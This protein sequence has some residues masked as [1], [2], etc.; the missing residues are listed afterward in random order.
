[1]SHALRFVSSVS[2]LIKIGVATSEFPNF[3]ILYGPNTSSPWG[4]LIYT[5][6]LQAQYNA[7]V[8]RELR[9]RNAHGNVFAMMAHPD[10]E[11]SYTE[12]LYPELAKLSTS[13]TFGCHSYYAN[14]KGINTHWFP[15]HQSFYKSLLRKIKWKDYVILERNG[16][17][18]ETYCV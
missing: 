15:F 4:S 18:V 12:S 8:V 16:K 10:V 7:R 1:M 14:S 6:E 11:K 9:T 5:F 2:N 13:T 3:L 17:G